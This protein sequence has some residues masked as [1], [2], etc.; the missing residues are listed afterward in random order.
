[1]TQECQNSTVFIVR[2]IGALLLGLMT[3]ATPTLAQSAVSTDQQVLE[4]L[5]QVRQLLE[6]L[7]NQNPAVGR[8]AP[9]HSAT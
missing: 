3:A 4:E 9:A 1:M 2:F 7:V 6:R 5:R 8:P